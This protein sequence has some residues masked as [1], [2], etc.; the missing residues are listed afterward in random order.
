MNAFKEF[1]DAFDEVVDHP[2]TSAS[3]AGNH[4]TL[5]VIRI[6]AGELHEQ[7]TK[8]EAA[9]I[10]AKVP[11]FVRAGEIV[12]PIVDEV[13]AAGDHKTKTARLVAVSADA[14]IDYLSRT[15]RWKRHDG[16]IKGGGAWVAADPPKAVAATL[17]ARDGEW[18]F[19]RLVGVITTPTLRPDGSILD[20]PGYDEE[21]RLVLLQPP[22]LPP[23]PKRPS[24]SDAQAALS[25]LSGLLEDFPF[26][27]E[28]SRSVALSALI[29][30]VVRG[31]LPVAPMH[32]ISAPSA[33]CGK[34]YLVDLASAIGTGQRCPLIAAGRDEGETDKRLG[35]ALMA[36]YPMLSIDN[37][38]GALGGDALCQ[39]VERPVVLIRVLGY[40][41]LKRI[42]SRATL[43]ATGNNLTPTGDVVRRVLLCR[44]DANHEPSRAQA[45][46]QGSVPRDP[47]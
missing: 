21:T 47:C 15:A 11:F 6:R 31:A 25:L 14:L 19:P 13:D 20:E 38:N 7:A 29:T 17:L 32:V 16:R 39:A 37:L 44:L 26:A 45:V 24:R 8:A 5:P 41:Q 23:L 35:A 12:R 1:P 18:T 36:G 27:D 22:S 9:L 43:F 42:E 3:Q 28:A 4:D 2:P 30:L 40:S 33:G 34:S 10:T 46:S